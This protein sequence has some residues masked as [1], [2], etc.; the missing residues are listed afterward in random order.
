MCFIPVPNVR[1]VYHNILPT[2][3]CSWYIYLH[4]PTFK[5]HPKKNCRIFLC[6]F[7]LAGPEPRSEGL[8]GDE[9]HDAQVVFVPMTGFPMGVD[10]IYPHEWLVFMVN[11][12]KYTISTWILWAD[13]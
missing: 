12:G 6:F 3:R 11:V 7:S 5:K 4:L 9:I 13:F 2:F 10:I 8:I 1:H